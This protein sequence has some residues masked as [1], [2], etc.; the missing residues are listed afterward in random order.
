[1]DDRE[2]QRAH[3]TWIRA[4]LGTPSQG[5]VTGVP[6]PVRDTGDSVG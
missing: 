4:V 2:P 3:G 5:C 6:A 1:M